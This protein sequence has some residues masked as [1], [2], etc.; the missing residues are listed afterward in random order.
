MKPIRI[1]LADDHAL[2]R[3]G[4]RALLGQLVGIDVV[5]E[6]NNGREALQKIEELR[7]D[8]VLMDVRM[9]ELNGLDATARAGRSTPK[10]RVVILSMTADPE[11]VLQALQ[12]GAA[13]YLLKNVSPTQ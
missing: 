6:A 13:G 4:L 8:V 1:L 2:L 3:A 11:T 12:S 10:S 5:G 7:P 9:P